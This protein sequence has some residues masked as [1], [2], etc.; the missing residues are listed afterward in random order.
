MH[1]EV[2]EDSLFSGSGLYAVPPE[3]PTE[4]HQL[5]YGYN[6]GVLHFQFERKNMIVEVP[7]KDRLL[8]LIPVMIM[9]LII[10]ILTRA[11]LFWYILPILEHNKVLTISFWNKH[12]WVYW[13]YFSQLIAFTVL[14]LNLMASTVATVNTPPGQ[15]PQELKLEAENIRENIFQVMISEKFLEKMKKFGNC[16]RKR[17]MFPRFCRSCLVVK[18]DRSHHCS[19]CNKC[20]LKMDHHCPYVNN[21]IGLKNYKYF[22]NMLISGTCTSLL[23]TFTMWE[24]V[25]LVWEDPD[26]TLNFQVCIGL[27]YFGNL[28]LSGILLAFSIFHIYLISKGLTTI[29]FREKMT[30]KFDKSPYHISCFQNFLA[31]FGSNP[32]FWFIPV[33]K[34]CLGLEEDDHMT[35]KNSE[36]I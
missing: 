20:V 7:Q 35:F 23:I 4:V 1:S 17:T 8:G 9:L 19:V 2:K 21:C 13:K 26:Y 5:P 12:N 30:V 34:S 28:I 25:G 36:I 27:A 29:E 10:I 15:I 31:V 14:G 3:I 32:L 24:G 11:Y 16:E 33:G 22:M 6:S 18:P